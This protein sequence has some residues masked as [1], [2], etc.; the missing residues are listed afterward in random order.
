MRK[1]VLSVAAVIALTT[2]LFA[3]NSQERKERIQASYLI[4]FGSLP[5]QGE[6]NYWMTDPLSLRSV[7]EL[8]EQHRRNMKNDVQLKYK[9]INNSYFDAM[10]RLPETREVNYWKAGNETYAEL[11]TKHVQWMAGNPAEFEKA[12]NF[13]Y[14]REFNRN[15]KPEEI[16]SWKNA[17]TRS[18]LGI[19]QE[20]RK[21]IAAGIFDEKK[22]QQVIKKSGV[23]EVKFS[24]AIANEVSKISAAGVISTGGGNCISVGGGNVIS[25]GGGN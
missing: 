21:N 5:Q 16:K 22:K 17:G 11:V 8:V 10:G 2:S 1:F 18:Y 15:A 4:A 13:S 20:H 14:L 23:V 7:N 3:Q 9:A 24:S 12:I 25:T 19:C 6:L